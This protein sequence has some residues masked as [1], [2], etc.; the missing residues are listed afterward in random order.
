MFLLI[1][2][3]LLRIGVHNKAVKALKLI[4]HQ[5]TLHIT[6]VLIVFCLLLANNRTACLNLESTY[7]L[8]KLIG[9][10]EHESKRQTHA[11]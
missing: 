11:L 8:P 4:S 5:Q 3:L 6:D 1:L 9:Y 7:C 2:Q 10:T